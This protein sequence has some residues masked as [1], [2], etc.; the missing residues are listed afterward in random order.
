MDTPGIV[1]EPAWSFAS[2]SVRSFASSKLVYILPLHSYRVGE[3]IVTIAQFWTNG[4]LSPETDACVSALRHVENE[5]VVEQP[6]S[7]NDNAVKERAS[8]F[9]R[10]N[11]PTVI[12]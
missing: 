4:G 7:P 8:G 1:F 3:L 11:T 2:Q 9:S 6:Q 12:C 5:G 10:S